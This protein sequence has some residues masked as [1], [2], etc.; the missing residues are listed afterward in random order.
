MTKGDTWEE[1]VEYITESVMTHAITMSLTYGVPH[2]SIHFAGSLIQYD[3]LWISNQSSDQGDAVL[4]SA[5]KL[6]ATSA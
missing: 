5:G 1:Q 6:V 4:L 3:D 2:F